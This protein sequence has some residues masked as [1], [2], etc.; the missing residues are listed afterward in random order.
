MSEKRPPD[1]P[2]SEPE[3]SYGLRWIDDGLF[4]KHTPANPYMKY[5][6]QNL[7]RMAGKAYDNSVSDYVL[8]CAY[9]NT[10]VTELELMNDHEA[11]EDSLRASLDE[12]IAARMKA[13]DGA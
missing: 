9:Y 3:P 1:F 10:D 2:V 11:A 6:T 5:V 4:W 8:Y 7:R 13:E 12:Y